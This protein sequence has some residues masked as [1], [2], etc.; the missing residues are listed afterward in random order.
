MQKVTVPAVPATDSG[1]DAEDKLS[2]GRIGLAIVFWGLVGLAGS[3]ALSIE[4]YLKENNPDY[5]LLCSI[6]PL[7]S[8]Q[9]AMGSWAGNLL[10][11]SNAYVG[12]VAF[13]ALIVFGILIWRGVALPKWIYW[14]LFAGVVGAMAFVI[15]FLIMSITVLQT[16]CP[17]CMVVWVAA[18]PLFVY[19]TALVMQERIVPAGVG[20]R[21]WFVKNRSIVLAALFAI[22]IAAV[23]LGFAD[24]W[25]YVF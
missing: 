10:G 19:I 8:C 7:V 18:I 5:E 24:K 15:F 20:L 9:G 2:R 1:L 12:T 3:V 11:F 14:G 22:V 17:Y 6:N 23:V 25:V 21:R 13:A 16:L 4:T